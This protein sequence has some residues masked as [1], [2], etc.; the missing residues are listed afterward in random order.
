MD[1]HERRRRVGEQVSAHEVSWLTRME[2]TERASERDTN[3]HLLIA[4]GVPA[5]RSICQGKGK[6]EGSK[7]GQ[8][9]APDTR[10]RLQRSVISSVDPPSLC[11]PLGKEPRWRAG[12]YYQLG[13]HSMFV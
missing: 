12:V 5:E 10:Q 4:S 2:R 7:D 11:R 1:G 9:T 3:Q 6:E 8:I 13:H